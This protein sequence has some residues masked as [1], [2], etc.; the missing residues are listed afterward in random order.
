MGKVAQVL[1]MDEKDVE[2]GGRWRW[3]ACAQGRTHVRWLGMWCVEAGKHVAPGPLGLWG[4]AAAE[5]APNICT[6]AG[7]KHSW[8]RPERAGSITGVGVSASRAAFLLSVLFPAEY[9]SEH[10]HFNSY[11]HWT[12]KKLNFR[13]KKY[14]FFK[15]IKSNEKLWLT[16][17]TNILAPP[18][19]PQFL[20]PLC[21]YLSLRTH[22]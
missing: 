22:I 15:N 6:A 1:L 5:P 21:H 12:W 18:Q 10:T 4:S 20:L 19:W 17:L 14:T 16:Y 7:W 3:V 8:P 9:P 2:V 13:F 11:D